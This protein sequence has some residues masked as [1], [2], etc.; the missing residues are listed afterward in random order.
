MKDR[1][2][3]RSGRDDTMHRMRQLHRMQFSPAGAV[4]AHHYDTLSL[5]NLG[6][7]RLNRLAWSQDVRV[8]VSYSRITA[9]Q[10]LPSTARDLT[11]RATEMHGASIQ[12]AIHHF[13]IAEQVQSWKSFADRA[14]SRR[15]VSQQEPRQPA[16]LP[17][18]IVQRQ[19]LVVAGSSRSMFDLLRRR[20]ATLHAD[21]PA[22]SLGETE[23]G[24]TD[25]LATCKRKT[26]M[27]KKK[28][29]L[30]EKHKQRR[31]TRSLAICFQIFL[32]WSLILG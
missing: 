9:M 3:P 14:K 30:E 7:N 24:R 29:M 28:E 12:A 2:R 23:S 4:G 15:L 5:I 27:M 1:E 22:R 26:N 10:P 25:R 8:P 19:T 32:Y 11:T 16:A 31:A 20:Q 6:N 13:V 21:A 18:E 17:D